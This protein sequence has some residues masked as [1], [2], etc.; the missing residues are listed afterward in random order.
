M[1]PGAV[2][3]AGQHG[4]DPKA[5]A[6]AAGER[7]KCLVP[8]AAHAV[9]RPRC[10]SNRVVT[11][12]STATTASSRSPAPAVATVAVVVGA[13]TAVAVEAAAAVA[14]T[15]GTVVAADTAAAEA[16]AAVVAADAAG[17]RSRGWRDGRLPRTAALADPRHQ[18]RASFVDKT[19]LAC[20]FWAASPESESCERPSIKVKMSR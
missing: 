20:F 12:R 9:K 14:V 1:N 6:A 8:R 3:L 10:L 16:V 7:E 11:A 17:N 13:A 4:A 18:K 19:K 5:A 2:R 15:V